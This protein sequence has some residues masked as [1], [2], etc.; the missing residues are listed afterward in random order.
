MARPPDITAAAV[1][2]IAAGAA[3]LG[4]DSFLREN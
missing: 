2:I 3:R 4:I 1:A